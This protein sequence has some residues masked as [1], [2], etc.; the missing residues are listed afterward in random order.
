M[1]VRISYW[2][3]RLA[4]PRSRRAAV[5]GLLVLAAAG[6]A[7]TML[8]LAALGAGTDRWFFVLVVWFALI[9]IP[10]WLL[11]AAFETLGPALRG[12]LAVRLAA[13]PD[14]YESAADTTLMVEDLFARHVVMPRIA[15]PLETAKAREAAA[16]LA[17]R[18]NRRASAPDALRAALIGCLA[19]VESWVQDL[20]TQAAHSPDIQARWGDVRALSALA[21]LCQAVMAVLEDQTGRPLAIGPDGRSV[22][23]LLEAVLDYCDDLALRVDAP[24][25]GEPPLGPRADP[26]TTARLR[27]VWQAY[28]ATPSPAPTPLRAFLTAALPD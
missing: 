23:A 20:G 18:A 24:P 11:T 21:G 1:R 27:D 9:F 22:R 14:R 13:R 12:R 4:D 3:S 15:T 28:A 19:C 5:R 10:L 26:E 7:L 17:V 16:A 25:W 2:L 8:V 6:F